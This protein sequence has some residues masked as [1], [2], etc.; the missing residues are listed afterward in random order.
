MTWKQV[1]AIVVPALLLVLIA[2]PAAQADLI[3]NGGFEAFTGTAP[4]TSTSGEKTSFSSANVTN[5]G[6]GG[7]GGLSYLAAPGTADNGSHIS[8]YGPF[9]ATSPN[10]GNF[11]M[12]DGDPNFRSSAITQQLHGL[13]IGQQY[14][15]SFY[16]AAGQQAGFSGSTTE[17]WQVGFGSQTQFSSLY[18]LPQGGIGPWELQTLIF[19]ANTTDPFLSFLAVGTATA[20]SGPPIVFLDGVSVTAVPEPTSLAAMGFVLVGLGISYKRQRAAKLAKPVTA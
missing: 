2:S 17:K 7:P 10:G 14:A 12:A 4:S 20:S 9:A 8:V 1:T 19:T 11:Y 5:W 6:G 16:Q 15:V 13:T 18:S 3:L